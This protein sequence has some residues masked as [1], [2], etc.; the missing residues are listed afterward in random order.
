MTRP[1]AM[2]AIPA[3]LI[4]GALFWAA[5][6]YAAHLAFAQVDLG[7]NV[8]RYMGVADAW[9]GPITGECDSACTMKLRHASCVAPDATL[10]FHDATSPIATEWMMEYYTPGLR[11]YVRAGG[12]TLTG[13]ELA[14]FGYRVCVP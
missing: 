13:A 8:Y 9:R 5:V 2:W 1:R 3:A 10:L 4:L 11:A 14:R 12:G 7:G 6:F